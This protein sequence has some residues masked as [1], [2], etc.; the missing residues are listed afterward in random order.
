MLLQSSGVMTDDAFDI[1]IDRLDHST[2][3][4]RMA[5]ILVAKKYADE[6]GMNY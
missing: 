3:K 6:Y 1:C 5:A 4:D 2:A